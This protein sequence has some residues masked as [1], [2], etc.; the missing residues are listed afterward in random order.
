VKITKQQF[1]THIAKEPQPIEE[2]PQVRVEISIPA[3]KLSWVEGY[4]DWLEDDDGDFAGIPLNSE[5][6][7]PDMTPAEKVSTA[8]TDAIGKRGFWGF[9][10]DWAIMDGLVE[11]VEF[12]DWEVEV[13]DEP[14]P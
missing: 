7:A 3:I 14:A 6:M 2:T 9:L 11:K 1:T 8:L 5:N 10:N 12:S 13:T 4:V